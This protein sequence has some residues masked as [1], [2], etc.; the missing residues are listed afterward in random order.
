VRLKTDWIG[1]V[2]EGKV[3]KR[4]KIKEYVHVIEC[5]MREE[6]HEGKTKKSKDVS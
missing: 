3:K 4:E 2:E 5:S 6:A 1:K